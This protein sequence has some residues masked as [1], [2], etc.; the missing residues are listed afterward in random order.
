MREQFCDF[1]AASLLNYEFHILL[2]GSDFL[3]WGLFIVVVVW[4]S[5]QFS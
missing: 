4:F 3:F 2:S 1:G 5:L